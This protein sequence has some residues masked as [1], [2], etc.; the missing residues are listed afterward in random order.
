[1]TDV[2]PVEQMKRREPKEWSREDYVDYLMGCYEK[3]F[4]SIDHK[5]CK[6]IAEMLKDS[7]S[8]GLIRSRLKEHHE[9]GLH[10]V[11]GCHSCFVSRGKPECACYGCVEL[12][13]LIGEKK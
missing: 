4:V 12:R 13:A 6:V 8:K 5:D 10:P 11:I 3:H 1:M 9:R 7:V 2:L